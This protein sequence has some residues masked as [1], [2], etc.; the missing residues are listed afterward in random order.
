MSVPWN[1]ELTISF[2][3]AVLRLRVIKTLD[4]FSCFRDYIPGVYALSAHVE[5]SAASG[6]LREPSALRNCLIFV[7]YGEWAGCTKTE[8]HST[9]SQ[10][11]TDSKERGSAPGI[12]N[13]KRI[14]FRI[15]R[16]RIFVRCPAVL[17]VAPSKEISRRAGLVLAPQDHQEAIACHEYRERPRGHVASL[18]V[19]GLATVLRVEF[20][21]APD[22][23]PT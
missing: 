6:D 22:L 3:G 12:P 11:A 1:G 16:F 21:F 7:E 4:V 2:S 20:R 14:L 10:S 19:C 8:R 23:F 5:V 9:S 13:S 15:E 17:P 18:F